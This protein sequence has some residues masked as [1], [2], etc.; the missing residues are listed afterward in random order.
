MSASALEAFLIIQFIMVIAALGHYLPMSMKQ[1]DVGIAGYMAIGAYVSA[2]LTRD[3]AA[4]FALALAAGAAM[5]AI[6]ALIVDALAT[7]IRIS[8]FAFGIFS[9][10]FAECLRVILNNTEY[11]GATTG[12]V[13]LPALTTLPI[14]ATILV[15]LI[16]AFWLFDRT[17]LGQLR[18]AIADDEFV[19]P[20]FGVPLLRT[21]LIV[22][23]MGGALGGLAGG[24]YVHYVVFMRPDDFGFTLL[25]AI[26]LPV[27]FG[28]LDR[29]YGAILGTLLLGILPEL[30]RDLG[31]FRLLITALATIVLLVVRP[32]GLLTH[33]TINSIAARFRS[34]T[35]GLL[36][37]S[38]AG[39]ETRS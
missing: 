17:R 23:A 38:K 8:G 34:L 14:V 39:M 26:Q 20:Q 36:R 19:V 30:V 15:V 5:A 21:K 9:L 2:V 13:G 31:Q 27:V 22:F 7:R 25:I 32:S 37:R 18:T 3:F 4:P 28:G 6:G 1:L 16:V 24:L 29:F 35:A 33:A 10:S 11:V 12:F